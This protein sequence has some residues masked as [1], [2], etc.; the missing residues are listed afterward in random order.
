[1][2]KR[3]GGPFPGHSKEVSKAHATKGRLTGTHS[4]FIDHSF[5]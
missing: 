3:K 1:M 2:A 5:R 4:E